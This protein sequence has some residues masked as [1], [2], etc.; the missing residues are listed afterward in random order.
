[1]SAFLAGLHGNNQSQRA[2]VDMVIRRRRHVE[3]RPPSPTAARAGDR[4]WKNT[5]GQGHADLRVME[6]VPTR[7]S[8]L[9][10]V[11]RLAIAT[12]RCR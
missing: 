7:H 11:R 2:V 6:L 1:V 10:S 3:R 4:Q 12:R 9:R 5:D 8:V